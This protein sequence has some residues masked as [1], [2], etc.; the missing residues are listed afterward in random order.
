MCHSQLS[1]VQPHPS[2]SNLASLS[3]TVMQVPSSPQDPESR[4]KMALPVVPCH[5]CC[6]CCWQSQ[7]YSSLKDRCR[8]SSILRALQRH[9][10]NASPFALLPG[11]EQ[12][13]L[14]SKTCTDHGIHQHREPL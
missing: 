11:S 5:G 7:L 12:A 9:M 3:I 6:Q 13:S 14:C 8:Q 10:G 2:A 4:A 1:H